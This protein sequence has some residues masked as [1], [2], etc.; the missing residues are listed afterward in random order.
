M[1]MTRT[2]TAARYAA[3][4][5]LPV[6]MLGLFLAAAPAPAQSPE[7]ELGPEKMALADAIVA[8]MID[9]IRYEGLRGERVDAAIRAWTDYHIARREITS[10]DSMIVQL[11]ARRAI[12]LYRQGVPHVPW[13]EKARRE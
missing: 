6:L 8:R 5:V 13:A 2:R 7:E 12:Q 1:T 3:A 10:R 4:L 9:G 11:Y